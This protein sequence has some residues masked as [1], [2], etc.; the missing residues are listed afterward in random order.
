MDKLFRIT[1]PEPTTF[2]ELYL[3]ILLSQAIRFMGSYYTHVRWARNA[4][5]GCNR[6]VEDSEFL[7]AYLAYFPAGGFNYCE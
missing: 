5:G 6:R 3:Y 2:Y 1:S 4:E 7:Y